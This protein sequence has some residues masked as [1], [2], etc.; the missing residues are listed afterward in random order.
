MLFIPSSIISGLTFP[1]VVVHELSHLLFCRLFK[2][3]VHE[4]CYFR[5]GN[6]AGYVIH[7]KP[8]KWTHQVLI[9]VGPFIINTLLG[10]F[11]AFPSALRTF[12][13]AE[14]GTPIDAILMWLGVSIA[15][16][17][18]PSRGDA[19]AIWATVNAGQVPYLAKLA[20]T[21][22]LGLIYILSFGAVFWLDLIYG[23]SA[24]LAIPKLLVNMLG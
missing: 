24:C 12:E 5:M 17:A 23:F 14:S 15:M 1:G 8:D 7:G 16:H 13:F 20:V 4:V 6:P 11:L 18:I 3:P 21:P 2:V 10:A 9:S 19:K 22:L